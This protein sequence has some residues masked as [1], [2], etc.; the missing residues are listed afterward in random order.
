M[1]THTIN[2]EERE[3]DAHPRREGCAPRILCRSWAGLYEW[4]WMMSTTPKIPLK[5]TPVDTFPS[6]R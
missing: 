3:V 2:G 1:T 5:T 6:K 4:S